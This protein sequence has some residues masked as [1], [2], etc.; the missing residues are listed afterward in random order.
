MDR[1]AWIEAG[2]IDTEIHYLKATF[3]RLD[4]WNGAGAWNC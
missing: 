3:D 4:A 1:S 2:E